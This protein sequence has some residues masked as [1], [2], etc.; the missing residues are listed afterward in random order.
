MLAG[1]EAGGR[2][3]DQDGDQGGQWADAGMGEQALGPGIGGSRLRDLRVELV[4]VGGEPSEQLQTVR[5][6]VGRVRWQGERLQLG[7]APLGPQ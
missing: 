4:D 6:A 7:Q 1:G 2:A 5:T 3:Q